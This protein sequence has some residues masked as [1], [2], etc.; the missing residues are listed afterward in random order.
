MEDFFGGAGVN[1]S[2]TLPYGTVQ[3]TDMSDY[4]TPTE[5]R[6]RKKSSGK[7]LGHKVSLFTH[8]QGLSGDGVDP[9]V[10]TS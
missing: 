4:L 3:L 10:M 9:A 8:T 7:Q 6:K 5:R 1:L 2:S